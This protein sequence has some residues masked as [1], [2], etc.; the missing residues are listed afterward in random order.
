M[1]RAARQRTRCVCPGWA[2][3]KDRGAEA[4]TSQLRGTE[5][6]R[7]LEAAAHRCYQLRVVM[8]DPLNCKISL[9]ITTQLTSPDSSACL[10]YSPF[11]LSQCDIPAPTFQWPY[12]NLSHLSCGSSLS[13]PPSCQVLPDHRITDHCKHCHCHAP[14][15]TSLQFHI[16]SKTQS[17]YLWP[18][19]MMAFHCH[20]KCDASTSCSYN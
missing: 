4:S 9:A 18:L 5:P 1:R 15:Q 17:S 3:K 20:L 6:Q 11:F 2:G 12:F 13:L 16:F 7:S 14:K 10:T 8:K 19:K